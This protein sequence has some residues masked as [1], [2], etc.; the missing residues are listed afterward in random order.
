MAIV[1]RRI[2]IVLDG[3]QHMGAPDRALARG[4]AMAYCELRGRGTETIFACD[5]GGFP[6]VAGHMRRFTEDP[7]VASFLADHIARSDISDVLSIE[8]IVIDDFDLA[9]FFL[10]DATDLGAASAL[11]RGFLDQ[12]KPVVHLYGSPLRHLRSEAGVIQMSATDLEWIR[13]LLP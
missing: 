8:Q 12:G 11:K 5:G 4:V 13:K 6:L 10:I 3:E 1:Q 9:A 2:L 7:V